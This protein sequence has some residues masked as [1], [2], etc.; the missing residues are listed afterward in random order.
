MVYLAATIGFFE[1]FW[2]QIITIALSCVPIIE[3][4]YAIVICSG[5]FPELTAM[6]LFILTQ[7]GAFLTAMVIL[8]LLTVKV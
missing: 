2:H 7:F 6:E 4:R 3:S 1:R 5:L 8:L